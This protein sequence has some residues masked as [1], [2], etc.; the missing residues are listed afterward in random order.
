VDRR[1]VEIA[2]RSFPAGVFTADVHVDRTFKGGPIPESILV[3]FTM[4]ISPA[5]S[6]GYSGLEA[7][8]YRILFLRRSDSNFELANPF[9]PPLPAIPQTERPG[10]A[11][12]LDAVI[13][14]LSSVLASPEVPETLKLGV[15]Y[16]LGATSSHAVVEI[17]RPFL[18]SPSVV[19]RAGTSAALLAQNYLPALEVAEKLL[20]NPPSSLPRYLLVNLSS[21]IG[22]S[23]RDDRAIPEL[24][25]LLKA[26]EADTRRAA[27]LALRNTGSNA[28][29]NALTIALH[30]SDPEVRYYAVIGLGEITNQPDWRPL[31]EDFMASEKKYTDYWLA[32]TA[33]HSI[34]PAPKRKG[35]GYG[36]SE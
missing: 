4:P 25:I 26:P 5:G 9:T 35:D 10:S 30:D 12:V 32:W 6:V 36:S 23:V 29:I 18:S 19:L 2:G 3:R 13:S 14:E 7:P 1:D 15:L 16:R 17:L 11:D 22:R 24:S 8:E 20:M 21:E 27:A 33:N 31:M 28:A 34:P